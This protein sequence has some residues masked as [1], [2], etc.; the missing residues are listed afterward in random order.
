MSKDKM[1]TRDNLSKKRRVGDTSC[2]FCGEEEF[3]SHLFFGCVV[4]KRAWEVLSVVL[5]VQVGANYE[6][7]TKLWLCNKK[8]AICN[9]FNSA[10]CWSLRKLRMHALW[11]GCL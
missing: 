6:S 8:Y 2:L 11:C 1:L 3:V 4:A 5:G 9:V 10:V 7:M